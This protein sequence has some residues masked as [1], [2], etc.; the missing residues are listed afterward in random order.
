MALACRTREKWA[1]E[2]P[3]DDSCA[4]TLCR[5][6]IDITESLRG[7]AF[8]MRLCSRHASGE[9]GENTKP[10]KSKSKDKGRDVVRSP[11]F[12]SAA[13]SNGGMCA[14][15]T[16]AHKSEQEGWIFVARVLRA[17]P[18]IFVGGDRVDFGHDPVDE[19]SGDVGFPS[20]APSNPGHLE[21][22]SN[23]LMHSR[24]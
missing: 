10:E 4:R 9:P 6:H 17:G 22:S 3:T 21:Y 1:G 5:R 19:I 12:C 8:R 20:S 11:D 18:R 14:A 2:V 15:M 7:Q 24:Y 23:N 13:E 16:A